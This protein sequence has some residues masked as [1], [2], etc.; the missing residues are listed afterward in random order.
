MSCFV[1]FW[2]D[3]KSVKYNLNASE[4]EGMRWFPLENFL[5]TKS[6]EQRIRTKQRDRFGNESNTSVLT[7]SIGIVYPRLK[8]YLE[9]ISIKDVKTYFPCVKISSSS[10]HDQS[11]ERPELEFILWGLTLRIL[12]TFL[13]IIDHTLPLMDYDYEFEIQLLEWFRRKYNELDLSYLRK[14][15]KEFN[16]MENSE[17]PIEKRINSPHPKSLLLERL[18]KL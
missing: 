7:F 10:I 14:F 11:L 9:M 3:L 8:Q 2:K 12:S 18:S 13:R 6:R 5:A 17:L 1:Y 4:V 16:E 15:Y